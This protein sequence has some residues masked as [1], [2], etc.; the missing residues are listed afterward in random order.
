MHRFR[1]KTCQAVQEKGKNEL[2]A[3]EI[4]FSLKFDMFAL[5]FFKLEMNFK[6]NIHFIRNFLKL[7]P[8]DSSLMVTVL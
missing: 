8:S 1:R 7:F 6:K 2:K 3:N 5:F 4:V